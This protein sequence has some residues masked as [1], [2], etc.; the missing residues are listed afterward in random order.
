MIRSNLV[1]VL[2]DSGLGEVWRHHL[3]ETKIRDCVPW[4]L[5]RYV[6]LSFGFGV[7]W[8]GDAAAVKAVFSIGT[9]EL[10]LLMDVGFEIER[11][12]EAEREDVLV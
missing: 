4:I 9:L 6:F 7:G 10:L 1:L 8:V 5:C 11:E 3:G 12:A 2:V